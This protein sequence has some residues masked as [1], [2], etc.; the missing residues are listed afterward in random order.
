MC[1]SH[2]NISFPCSICSKSVKSN[3]KAL[4]CDNCC[5]WT[6]L[7]CT[8]LT[9]TDYIALSNDPS[10]W[11]CVRCLSYMFPFNAIASNLEFNCALFNY[12]YNNSINADIIKNQKQLY[13]TK[14]LNICDNFDPDKHFYHQYNKYYLEDDF[15]KLLAEKNVA[16]NFS[17][18]HVN[19]TSLFKNL[20]NLIN[21]L[22]IISH[23]FSVIAV[24]GTWG[25]VNNDMFLNIPGYNRILVNSKTG[26][27]GGV[28][29]FVLN[30]LHFTSVQILMLLLTI[31]SNVVL[32]KN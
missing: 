10:S 23:R 2:S 1:C 22:S 9:V 24:S 18:L 28:A 7:K 16:T 15:N 6:H 30:N 31:I 8:S 32:L 20:D 21:Y 4:L 29:L 19:S 12:S 25:N 14:G 17:L 26:T 27:G 3:Q 13:L 11:F 5:K